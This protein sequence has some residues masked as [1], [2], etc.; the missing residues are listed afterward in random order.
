LLRRITGFLIPGSQAV[1]DGRVL[2][3][4][5]SAFLAWFFLTGALVWLPL[6]IPRI[7]PLAVFGHIQTAFLVLFVLIALRSGITSWSRR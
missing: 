1:L 6:F 2:R 4:F 3:G 7:E 5:V